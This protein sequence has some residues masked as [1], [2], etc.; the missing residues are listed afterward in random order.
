LPLPM[1]ETELNAC[2]DFVKARLSNYLLERGQRFDIVAAVQEVQGSNPYRASRACAQLTAWTNRKDWSEILPAFSRC[3]RITRDIKQDFKP[4]PTLMES[5]EEKT[6]YQSI[7]KALQQPRENGS[8]DD[9]LNA[10]TPIIPSV[11]LFFD[12]VLVMAEDPKMRESRLGLLQHIVSL[13]DTVI[14][15]SKLEGF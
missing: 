12:K 9:M 11:N 4:D 2:L 1:Q 3:V 10:F 6:L 5:E 8:V 14:D 13:A 7:E 15:F